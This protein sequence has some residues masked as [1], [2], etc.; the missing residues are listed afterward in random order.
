MNHYLGNSETR[1][2]CNHGLKN[3]VHSA[4]LLIY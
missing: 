4:D 3:S 2:K 1:E